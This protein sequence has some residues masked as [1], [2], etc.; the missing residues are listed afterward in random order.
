M[1]I[2]NVTKSRLSLT[3]RWAKVAEGISVGYG[4]DLFSVS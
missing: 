2:E 4:R 3:K 1:D